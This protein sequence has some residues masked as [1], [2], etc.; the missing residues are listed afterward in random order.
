MPRQ[1]L[2]QLIRETLADQWVGDAVSAEM[3]A[4]LARWHYAQVLRWNRSGSI[5]TPYGV[6]WAGQFF[7]NTWIVR[8]DGLSLCKANGLQVVFSTR[9]AA[10]AAGLLHLADGF[11]TGKPLDDG[12]RW[13]KSH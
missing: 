9:A 3:A 6:L 11:G 12:L 7:H 1:S 8:R 10:R 13:G 4:A 5:D 2:K